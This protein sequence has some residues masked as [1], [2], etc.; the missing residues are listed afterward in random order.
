MGG[1]RMKGT[2]KRVGKVASGVG[3][4]RR[5]RRNVQLEKLS[6]GLVKEEKKEASASSPSVYRVRP[7]PLNFGF[8]VSA[9]PLSPPP[10]GEHCSREWLP[11]T[12]IIRVRSMRTTT[13][14]TEHPPPAA[15]HRSS[16]ARKTAVFERQCIVNVKMQR[17]SSRR[18]PVLIFL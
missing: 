6:R 3:R 17:N 4:R 13:I 16:S 10:G 2:V 8:S 5:R 11:P 7:D 9:R 18:V 1:V 14:T 15:A 12:Y